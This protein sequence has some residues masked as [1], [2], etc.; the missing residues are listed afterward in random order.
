LLQGFFF[1]Q[2]RQVGLRP[3]IDIRRCLGA[4]FLLGDY[5]RRHRVHF[6][7]RGE[8]NLHIETE[9]L[10]ECG[11]QNCQR[12]RSAEGLRPGNESQLGFFLRRSDQLVDFL[13]GEN[14]VE[15]THA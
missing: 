2:Q 14:G 3:V 1:V 8:A 11:F 12:F 4:A 13:R 10:V 15:R 7:A 6:R 9:P 5:P